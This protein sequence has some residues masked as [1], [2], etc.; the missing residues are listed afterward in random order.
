VHDGVRARRARREKEEAERSQVQERFRTT[1]VRE[2]RTRPVRDFDFSALVAEH[3]TPRFEADAA[4]AAVYRRFS[5]RVVADGVITAEERTRM[6]RLARMLEIG[7]ERVVV[8]EAAAKS[9]RFRGAVDEVLAD[10]VVTED[11]A[12][13]LEALRVS[14]G[15][16]R[17][18]W[19]RGLE[20]VRAAKLGPSSGNGG[21]LDG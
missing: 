14:L 20:R 12:L 9:E 19:T 6:D 10:G 18:D 7:A 2:L 4:A 11:E 3:D 17:A 13:S 5:D 15:I 16:G 21:T 1:L 8:I